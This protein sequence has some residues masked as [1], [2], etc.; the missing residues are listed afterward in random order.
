MPEKDGYKTLDVITE[1][2][3]VPVQRIRLA[4]AALNIQTFSFATD[5]RHRYYSRE[6]VQ[7]IREWLATH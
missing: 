4:I 6:D 7:R 2:L 1:E 5:R 3:A